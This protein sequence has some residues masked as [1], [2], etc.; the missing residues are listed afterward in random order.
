MTPKEIILNILSKNKLNNS[1][2]GVG[3]PVSSTTIEQMEMT[4]SFLP[5][6]HKDAGKMFE[7]AR[8]NYEILDYDMIVP[9]FSVVI[10][11]YALGCKVDWGRPDM[12][13]QIRGNIWESYEDIDIKKDFV[14]NHAIK[15]VLKCISMLKKS[16][17]DVVIAVKVFGT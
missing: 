11:S 8:A 17:P 5:E 1:R 16:Y 9:I 10:E 2:P 13:P 6:A 7:L 15:A 4:G 14:S 12:M 3:N